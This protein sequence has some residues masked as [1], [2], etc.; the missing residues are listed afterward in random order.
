MRY[1]YIIFL[2]SI[3]S[4]LQ[5]TETKDRSSTGKSAER[6]TIPEL[7]N[8]PAEKPVASYVVPMGDLRLDRKFGVNIYETR[9]TFKFLLEMYYDGTIQN[10]TLNIPNFGTWPV[11][12]VMPGE[13]RLS[14]IIGFLD[15]EN[16]FREYK[17]LSAEDDQ[18]SLKV[19]K[20][21]GVY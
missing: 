15:T 14:C 11:V 7:R 1:C 20:S 17:L 3:T 16:S 4:C 10:D 8:N 12:K 19:L 9:F 6:T 2:F 5:N 13:K 18:L 21:Y